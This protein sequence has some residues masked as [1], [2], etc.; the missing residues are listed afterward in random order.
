MSIENQRYICDCGSSIK[1]NKYSIVAHQD[2]IAHQRFLGKSVERKQIVNRK[3]V[4]NRKRTKTPLYD[5]PISVLASMKMED[6]PSGRIDEVKA[7]KK[8][9]NAKY[10]LLSKL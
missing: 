4:V 1:N 10:R 5:R 9:L 3:K 7:Y 8:E 2:S 6:V